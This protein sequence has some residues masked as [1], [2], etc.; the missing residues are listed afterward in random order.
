MILTALALSLLFL[1]LAQH[2]FVTY[3]LSLRLVRY[4]RGPA[5][6]MPSSARE[7][8]FAICM[9]A[10]NEEAIIVRKIAN[11]LELK[12]TVAECQILI[13]VDAATDRTAD[14]LSTYRD[15]IT[16]VVGTE[17][18]GKSH[19]L[20]ELVGRTTADLLVFTD[21]N[22]EID[23]LALVRIGARFRD[24]RIGC[25][26]GHLLYTNG[27]ETAAASA[28]SLYWRIEEGI[29]QLESDTIGIIGADGSLFAIRRALHQ[30]VPPDIIDDFY[31]SM[32]ILLAG[33]RVVR[34]PQALAFERT[35]SDNREE[36]RRKIR[37]ACQAFNVHRLI[38]PAVTSSNAIL[39]GYVSH[40]LLKWLTIYNLGLFATFFAWAMFL[41][42][43]IQYFMALLFAAMALSAYIAFGNSRLV[44]QLRSMF[45]GL[46]GPGVG[47][48]RSLRGDRFQTWQPL[49]T[50]RRAT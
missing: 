22:V 1:V 19:G 7:P 3:P 39:Y 32:R 20:N 49:S 25:V 6:D 28:G 12:S 46:L 33:Y 38:W 24:A 14:L 2:P 16:L 10:F 13:Y 43:P 15:Q 50:V 30:P 27:S 35:A 47:V 48:W 5:R 42:V 4:L 41:A 17:R 45:L 40:R 44:A 36:F 18:H 23:H 21:A 9:S 31:I 26:C 11:L 34:E 29:K 8:S 37:I